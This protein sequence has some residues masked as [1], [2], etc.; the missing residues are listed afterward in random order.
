VVSGAMGRVSTQ[1]DELAGG[2]PVAYRPLGPLG[3]E[4]VELGIVVLAG[5]DDGVTE[6]S[7]AS[8]C[9]AGAGGGGVG[10]LSTAA[11][12]AVLVGGVVMAGAAAGEGGAGGAVVGAGFASGGAGRSVSQ[13]T[14]VMDAKPTR[15]AATHASG[16]TTARPP[17]L[18]YK[19]RRAASW[20]GA[21]DSPSASPC[22]PAPS[23]S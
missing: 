15:N 3:D 19:E 4:V 17:I 1:P 12:L 6:G 8:A 5:T 18:A 9:G 16:T 23:C 7:G 13:S 22:P 10:S 14:A 2:D 21:R 11:A 20:S